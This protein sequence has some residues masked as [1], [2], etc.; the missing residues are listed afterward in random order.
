MINTFSEVIKV[1]TLSER[2]EFAL[3]IR[4]MKQ[5]DIVKATG[6]S[7]GLVSQIC[8]GKTTNPKLNHIMA[9]AKALNVS[10]DY[11]AGMKE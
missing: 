8:S 11:L 6:L 2:I 7:S 4:N 10:L 1:S 9:I 3:E 5:A